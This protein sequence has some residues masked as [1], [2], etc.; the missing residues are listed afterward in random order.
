MLF[1][2]TNHYLFTE[3]YEILCGNFAEIF[4]V[5]TGGM[6]SNHCA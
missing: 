2:K 6:R 1:K 4:N 5:K 3:S